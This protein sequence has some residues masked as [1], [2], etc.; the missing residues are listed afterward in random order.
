MLKNKNND[1][2]KDKLYNV[3]QKSVISSKY[4][5]YSPAKIRL[6]AI[7]SGFYTFRGRN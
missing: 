4:K 7:P 2:D 6:V 1:N 3:L 5:K